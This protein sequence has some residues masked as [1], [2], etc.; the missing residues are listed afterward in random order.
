MSN[1][2]LPPVIMLLGSSMPNYF[3][4]LRQGKILPK[5]YFNIFLTTLIVVIN[6]PFQ[7]WEKLLFALKLKKTS[8]QKPPLFILGHWRSGTTLLHNMLCT[9]P[10]ASFVTTYQG[11]FP[12]N[13]ASKAVFKTFMRKFMP[14]KRPSDNMRLDVDMPQEDEFA[15]CSTYHNAF[16]NFFYFPRNYQN[17]YKKSIRFEEMNTAEKERWYRA[18]DKLL[19][20]AYVN[21]KGKR[22]IVKNPSNTARIKQLLKLYPDAKFLYIYR[23]P[24]TVYLSTQRFFHSLLPTISLD[25]ASADFVDEMIFDLYKMLMGD[26]QKQVSLIPKANLMELRFEDFEK[27]PVRHL[28]IIYKD[29]LQEDFGRVKNIFTKHFEANK[30]YHKNSYKV[31]RELIEKIKTEFGFYMELYG[32]K[33]PEEIE[34]I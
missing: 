20:K 14:N 17:F 26:Y 24:I 25:G 27:E 4:V 32:Y 31:K 7:L 28:E 30:D 3:R 9:D 18:Y 21:K 10:E 8:F 1:F 2:K 33:V 6:I 22:L 5:Y 23:N 19:K 29:L 15:F 16:Y 11:V 13:L 34:V 12:N